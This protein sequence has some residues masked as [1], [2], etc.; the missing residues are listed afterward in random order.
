MRY[1]LE[2]VSFF[3]IISNAHQDLKPENVLLNDNISDFGFSCHLESREKL[4]EFFGTPGYL[5]PE[6]F[7]CS[8]DKTH[9]GYSKKVD[10][11]ACGVILFTF[12]TGSSSFWHQHLIL[13]LC[14]IMEGQYQFISPKW[15]MF[16]Y[17]QRPD[18][19]VAASGS[20]EAPDS[21]A[22]ITTLLLWSLWRQPNLDPHLLPVVP[23]GSL[24]NNGCWISDLK[25][26]PCSTTDQKCTIEGSLCTV[27][28]LAPHWKLTRVLGE[29]G[30]A[31][32]SGS[33]FPEL[34]ALIFPHHWYRR[35]EGLSFCQQG[36]G[37]A[38]SGL[39]PQIWKL[40]KGHLT[41]RRIFNIL[42][43]LSSLRPPCLAVWSK[44]QSPALSTYH[45]WSGLCHQSW[46]KRKS[47]R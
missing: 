29:E 32:K 24:D 9:T 4:W 44:S 14:M 31:T 1:L 35:G 40:T 12:L 23:R 22:S 34:A 30:W 26:P 20:W 16:K 13:I 47:L 19:M 3:H 41:K 45:Y 28:Y 25:H 17:H 2:A 5:A 37:T 36:W 18:L 11:W 38:G 42:L 33:P 10:L 43:P 15:M 46:G 21:R 7:K 6:I 39:A 27:A 8:M